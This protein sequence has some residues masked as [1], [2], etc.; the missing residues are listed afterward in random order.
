MSSSTTKIVSNTEYKRTVFINCT[1]T[2]IL[3][4]SKCVCVSRRLNKLDVFEWIS[5]SSNLDYIRSINCASNFNFWA[6][7]NE[8][9][10]T[11]ET[12]YI[13]SVFCPSNTCCEIIWS[14]SVNNDYVIVI[15]FSCCVRW[16]KRSEETNFTIWIVS[17]QLLNNLVVRSCS[18]CW[19]CNYENFPESWYFCM[20]CIEHS[21]TVWSILIK[22]SHNIIFKKYHPP[23]FRSIKEIRTFLFWLR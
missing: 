16:R 9:I 17:K 2:T 19:I 10:S 8:V 15:T 4:D 13:D 23:S 6:L 7:L 11:I 12:D 20:D 14:S 5:Y 1:F 21:S 18:V 3:Y 22:R